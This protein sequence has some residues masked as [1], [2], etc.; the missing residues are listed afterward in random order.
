MSDQILQLWQRPESIREL[1]VDDLYGTRRS[2]LL[3]GSRLQDLEARK[4]CLLLVHLTARPDPPEAEVVDGW[5]DVVALV[6]KVF[7]KTEN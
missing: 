6:S 1:L 3:L 2:L 7:R 4:A 5:S